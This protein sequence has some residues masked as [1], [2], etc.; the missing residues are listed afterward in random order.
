[1]PIELTRELAMAA[2]MDE[3]NRAMRSG[4]RSAWSEEDYAIVRKTFNRLWPLCE[5]GIEPGFFCFH[6]DRP[7]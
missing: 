2:S 1:M 5:H 6:C 3:G 7:S 4:G